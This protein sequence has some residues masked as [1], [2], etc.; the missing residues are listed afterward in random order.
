VGRSFRTARALQSPLRID[1]WV[2]TEALLAEMREPSRQMFYL[3]GTPKA[4]IRQ[5]EKKWL[6]LLHQLQLT[7]PAQPPPRIQLQPEV[8]PPGMLRL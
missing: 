4:R 2:P 8:F 1:W 3:V 5:H 6:D 7:L